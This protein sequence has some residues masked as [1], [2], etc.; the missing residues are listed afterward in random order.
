MKALILVGGYGTRLRPLTLTRPK[1]LV[2]FCNK[3]MLLHQVEALAQAGVNHVIL[4]VSYLS[5]MLEME[6][7]K[8]EEKLGITISMS[9]EVEP[10]GTAGPLS[11]AKGWLEETDEPFFVLNSDITCEYPFAKMIAFHKEHGKE[12]TI[13]VTKVDEPSKYGVVV[14]EQESGK[15]QKFVEKPTEFVSNKINAGMYIFNPSILKRIEPRPMSIEKEVFPYM[16]NDDQLYCLE[17]GGY[18]MDIGQPKDFITGTCMHL[19]ALRKTSPDCLYNGPGCVGNVLVHPTAK[20][21][22]DVRIGPNVVVG[23]EA[24]IEKGTCISKCVIMKG[25]RIKSH[26]WVQNSIIGWRSSIGRWVRME[27]VCVLGEDVH[28]KDELYLNG[29]KVLPHKSLAASIPQPN[30]VM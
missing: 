25:A 15:I 7:R 19:N 17:L 28:I 13:V 2:E 16:A 9:H 24:V 18:W 1:P 6:L 20:V 30:I 14:Y 21:D 27:G 8:E 12:G 10:L 3:P 29:A 23:P 4:A 26:S 11:L 22:P 5:E